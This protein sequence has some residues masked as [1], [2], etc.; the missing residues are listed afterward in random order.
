M[1]FDIHS[2]ILPSVDD[3]SQSMSESLQ[4][5]SLMRSQGITDVIATPHFYP[6]EDTFDDYKCRIAKAYKALLKETE[7]KDL[8]NIYLGSEVLYYR[9]IGNSES[10]FELC[11]NNSRYLLLELTDECICKEFFEDMENLYNKLG[12]TP[13]IAHLERYCYAPNYKKL[14]KYIKN[15]ALLAQINASSLF[16]QSRKVTEKLIKG[17]YV[18]FIAT[19]AHSVTRRPPLMKQ[20]LAEIADSLGSEYASGFIR[21]SQILL[22]KICEVTNEQQ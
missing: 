3:G 14:L 18:N 9:Y 17:G 12:I 19:D 13:I 10:V 5:L 6:L 21:N 2:H 15:S 11:L 8:P 22:E 16:S 20:A 7:G 1:L 4:L